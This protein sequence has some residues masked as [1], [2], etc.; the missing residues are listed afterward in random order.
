[1][2]RY[3]M[4]LL[5]SLLFH[6]GICQQSSNYSMEEFCEELSDNLTKL[7]LPPYHDCPDP[8]ICMRSEGNNVGLAFGITIGAGLSTNLGA[9]LFFFPCFKRSNVTLLAVGLALAAGFMV[10]IAFVEV[11]EET[12]DYFCCHTQTHFNLAAT[13]CFFLGILLTL[14]L[15]F[16]LDSLQKLD[17]GCSPPWS[18]KKTSQEKKF[19]TEDDEVNCSK[20]LKSL[21]SKITGDS[22]QEGD[23][24]ISS[25]KKEKVGS[26]SNPT[27]IVIESEVESESN[28]ALKKFDDALDS[29]EIVCVTD[30]NGEVS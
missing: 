26:V 9:L 2:K 5:V 20:M 7:C 1:M 25:T 29:S 28:G 10:Y 18:K 24:D 16:L 23:R 19:I 30:E 12:R 6:L 3:S 21:K 27:K 17:I 8:D 13:G 11:L 4:I 15:Q 14:V 22:F